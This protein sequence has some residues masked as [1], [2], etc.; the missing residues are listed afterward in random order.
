[1]DG[2][3]TYQLLKRSLQTELLKMLEMGG[4]WSDEEIMNQIDDLIVSTSKNIY[5]SGLKK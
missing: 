3:D 5:L 1:M 4:E 2:K